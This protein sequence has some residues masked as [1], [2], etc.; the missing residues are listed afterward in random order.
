MKQLF[1]ER[2]AKAT[3]I[4][5][6]RMDS[7][8][9]GKLERIIREYDE[10]FGIAVKIT[11]TVRFV[12]TPDKIVLDDTENRR[13]V[14]VYSRDSHSLEMKSDDDLYEDALN[15][16]GE[17]ERVSKTINEVIGNIESKLDVVSRILD[18]G[19]EDRKIF[20]PPAEPFHRPAMFYDETPPAGQPE[21]ESGVSGYPEEDELPEQ[22]FPMEE[23]PAGEPFVNEEKPEENVSFPDNKEEE[24]SAQPA[25]TPEEQMARNVVEKAHNPFEAMRVLKSLGYAPEDFTKYGLSAKDVNEY[26]ELLKKQQESMEE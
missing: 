10:D 23:E 4:V 7:D 20:T 19:F 25:S 15:F 2:V 16:L 17:F 18:E 5:C 21:A 6:S 9:K 14:F 8:F 24:V 12:L 22:G 11:D 13:Y 1:K 3:D 26:V